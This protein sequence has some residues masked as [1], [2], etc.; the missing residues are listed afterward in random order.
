M[1]TAL[2][3]LVASQLAQQSS[4]PSLPAI[5]WLGPAAALLA[6]LFA[7]LFYRQ[8]MTE[9][10]GTER[11]REIATAVREGAMAYLGRQYRVVAVVFGVLF[12]VFLILSFLQLQN[13]IVPIAFLTGGFFS[14]LC[15][16]FGMRTA[17]AAAARV[18][19]A[20]RT[21]LNS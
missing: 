5:W 6:L 12:V 10:E 17:T 9:S 21:S 18:A 20:S 1:E 14:A 7:W 8:V 3:N 4:R 15:G 16:F 11:M 2:L 19:N 13:P